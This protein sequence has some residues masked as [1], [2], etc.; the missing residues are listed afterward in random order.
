[1]LICR[2][3]AAPNAV[4]SIRIFAYPPAALASDTKEKDFFETKLEIFFAVSLESSLLF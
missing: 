2:K 3:T 4:L 1:L